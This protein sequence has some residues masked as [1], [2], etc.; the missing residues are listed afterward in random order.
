MKVSVPSIAPISPP[1]TGASSIEAPSSVARAASRRAIAGAIVLES[2]ITVPV[3]HRAERRRFALEH[4]RHVGSVRQH[5]DDVLRAVRATSAGEPAA[6]APSLT[7]SSTAPRLRLWTMTEKPF[8]RRLRAMGLPMRPRP[9]KPTVCD[10]AGM[11]VRTIPQPGDDVDD[12]GDRREPECQ[13]NERDDGS[14]A[15][16]RAADHEPSR[17]RNFVAADE[18]ARGPRADARQGHAAPDYQVQA[19]RAAPGTPPPTPHT[20]T[21]AV[22]RTVRS[23]GSLGARQSLPQG[24]RLGSRRRDRARLLRV[25]G[26]VRRRIAIDIVIAHL[27]VL[28]DGESILVREQRADAALCG[29][30]AILPLLVSRTE[31]MAGVVIAVFGGVELPVRRADLARDR[32]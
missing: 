11:I 30:V 9:M 4:L 3:G 21:V 25:P 27:Q 29:R 31:L 19:H 26:N 22:C 24:S 17:R 5:R 18:C 28:D 14:N 6:V 23:P 32:A 16:L 15:V 1:L 10:M 8:L 13:R 7:S 12:Q 2:T 20:T